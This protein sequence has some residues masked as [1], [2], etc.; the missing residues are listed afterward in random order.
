[1]DGIVSEAKEVGIEVMTPNELAKLKELWR[2]S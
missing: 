1:V 2:V